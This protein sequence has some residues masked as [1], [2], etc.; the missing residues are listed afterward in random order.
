MDKIIKYR[1]LLVLIILV[2]SVAIVSAQNTN[3]ESSTIT[4]SGKVNCVHPINGTL[5]MVIVFNKSQGF[6]TV[7]RQDGSFSI[8]MNKSDTIVFST[9]EH[10]DYVYS[11][12]DYDNYE[13]HSI[14]IVMVT[15]AVWL[16]TVTVIGAKSLEQFR[17]EI[18]SL[19]IPQGNTNLALPVVSKY[20]KQLSTGDGG[21]D[22]VGP[23]TYLQHKFNK[24]NRLKKKVSH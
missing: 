18:L 16:N 1:V 19:D 5:S 14:D 11:L 12:Q 24:Y 4:L 21:T 23:L 8:E 20:A 7:S 22:L 10:Q 9:A 13:D 15:D 6:G 2:F 17:K 3:K